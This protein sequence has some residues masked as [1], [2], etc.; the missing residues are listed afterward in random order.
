MSGM[1]IKLVNHPQPWSTKF[2]TPTFTATDTSWH[3]TNADFIGRPVSPEMLKGE[4]G[5]SGLSPRRHYRN[6]GPLCVP[7]KGAGGQMTRWDVGHVGKRVAE[8]LLHPFNPLETTSNI[9]ERW[10]PLNE[11]FPSPKSFKPANVGGKWSVGFIR[12]SLDLT[13]RPA[14]HT[15]TVASANKDSPKASPNS[16]GAWSYRHLRPSETMRST[17]RPTTSGIPNR[18]DNRNN[19][20]PK[21]AREQSFHPS[22]AAAPDSSTPGRYGKWNF[23]G[24]HI[25]YISRSKVSGVSLL[26]FRA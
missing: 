14:F 21:T 18:K 4:D 6:V 16:S 22:R 26:G 20:R 9:E 23:G 11:A 2:V 19:E 25:D 24:S 7:E 5:H 15:A 10:R 3:G 8:P 17:D 12:P 1:E 13:S